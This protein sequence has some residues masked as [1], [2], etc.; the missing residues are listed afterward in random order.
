LKGK[1]VQGH[2]GDQTIKGCEDVRCIEMVQY[3]VKWFEWC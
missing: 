3:H 2:E 1:K